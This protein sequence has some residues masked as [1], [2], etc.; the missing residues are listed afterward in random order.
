ML[1]GG[2]LVTQKGFLFHLISCAHRRRVR[3]NEKIIAG[4]CAGQR[5]TDG[6]TMV[7]P[8]AHLAR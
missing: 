4:R 8:L 5:F 7:Y 6:C 3:E 2:W 1:A